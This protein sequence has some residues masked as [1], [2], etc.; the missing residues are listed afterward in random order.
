MLTPA[1]EILKVFVLHKPDAIVRFLITIEYRGFVRFEPETVQPHGSPVSVPSD[2]RS[3]V[4]HSVIEIGLH[5]IYYI[6][7]IR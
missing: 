1:V 5:G 6:D 3:A 2:T 4:G 7:A